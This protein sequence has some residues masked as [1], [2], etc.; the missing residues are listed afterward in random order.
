[1]S[2]ITG[3]NRVGAIRKFREGSNGTGWGCA[4][5]VGGLLCTAPRYSLCVAPGRPNDRNPRE[6]RFMPTAPLRDPVT[7]SA[8]GGR[9]AQHDLT[10]IDL[11]CIYIVMSLRPGRLRPNQFSFELSTEL[12]E[13]LKQLKAEHGTPVAESIRRAIAAWLDSKGI[14]QKGGAKKPSRGKK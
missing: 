9:Y 5:G 12:H 13:G 2:P 7:T 3:P 1:M 10:C 4:P 11:S 14:T 8:I 6:S